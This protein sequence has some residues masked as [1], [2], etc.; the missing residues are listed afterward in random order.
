MDNIRDWNP[1]WRESQSVAQLSG[2][3]RTETDFLI[4]TLHDNKVTIISGIRRAGKTTL[5]YQLIEHLLVKGTD[6]HNILFLGLE[7]NAFL[8]MEI[9]DLLGEF[10]REL[11][12]PGRTYVFLDEIQAKPGWERI[13]RKENDIRRDQKIVISGSS[14]RILTGEYATLL[15]GRNLTFYV[16]PLSFRDYVSFTVGL[17]IVPSGT[18]DLEK[19]DS[20]VRRYMAV[21]GFPEVILE[22]EVLRKATLNQYF[23]D[24]LHRDI[25]G[26]YRADPIKVTKLAAYLASNVGKNVTLSSLRRAIGLSYDAIRDYL[27]YLTRAGLFHLIREFSFGEKPTVSESKKHKVYCADLGMARNFYG[28]RA[29]DDGRFAE[30]AVLL[31]LVQRGYQPTFFQ[32]KKEIDFVVWDPERITLINVCNADVIPQ[33]E[34][35]GFR[36]FDRIH[37]KAK[38]EKM[39]ITKIKKG[40]EEGVDHYPLAQWL[41]REKEK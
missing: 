10:R 23:T 19:L 37:P 26:Q 17:E 41:Y 29:K 16:R 38:T 2:R 6:P 4:Q 11:D 3:K 7:D 30:N 24:I 5:M 25:I 27:E 20:L 31:D 18:G 35:E 14:S 15:T 8:N 13:I 32:G 1:W 12:P 33:R 21:G 39:I 22:S 40:E 34:Y 28:R 36:E 9:T